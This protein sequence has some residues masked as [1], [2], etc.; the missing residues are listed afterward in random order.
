MYKRQA[1]LTPVKIAVAAVVYVALV[2]WVV[3]FARRAVR[4]G[5]SGDLEESAAGYVD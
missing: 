3:V 4:A 2:A 1:L 5:L